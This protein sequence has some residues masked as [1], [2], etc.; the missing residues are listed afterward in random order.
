MTTRY[1][2]IYNAAGKPDTSGNA[3]LNSMATILSNDLVDGTAWTLKNAGSAKIKLGRRFKIP[4]DYVQNPRFVIAFISGT[5]TNNIVAFA[6]YKVHTPTASYD[7]SAFDETLSSGAVA[8]AGTARVGFEATLTPSTPSNFVAGSIC[9]VSL[10][11][12]KS[13][14][15]D[16]HAADVHV[17]GIWF[18]YDDA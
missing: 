4:A 5:T 12:D 16:N 15:S 18:K 13:S 3:F 10:G 11:R 8:V 6:D 14:G 17:V 7:P 9:Q 2:D 1:H